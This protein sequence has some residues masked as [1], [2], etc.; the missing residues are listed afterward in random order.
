MRTWGHPFLVLNLD[1]TLV[2][3]ERLLA[4]PHIWVDLTHL[5]GKVACATPATLAA[6]EAALA[7]HGDVPICL[8]GAGEYHYV[9][10]ARLRALRL[11]VTLVLFDQHHDCAPVQDGIITCGD[12]VRHALA[13]PWVQRV[14]WIGG[15]PQDGPVPDTHPKLVRVDRMDPPAQGAAWLARTVP[16][17]HVYVSVDKDVLCPDDATTTWGAGRM[18]LASLLAW[19][20]LL[21]AH[22]RLAGA[23]VG[24]EWALPPGRVMPTLAD[25]QATA[26]NEAANLA[27]LAALEEWLVPGWLGAAG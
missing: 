6:V 27:I 22:R 26:R 15:L 16:T 10:Y 14:V 8:W 24:G 4:L 17:R 23:D 12:W 13:L 20:R 5:R 19:I 1:G 25:R 3:Q 9:T 11:P 21:A 2:G 18:P 7:P